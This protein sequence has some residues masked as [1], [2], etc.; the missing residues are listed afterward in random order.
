MNSTD[1]LQQKIRS[2]PDLDF[3]TIVN[4]SIELYK[5][6]WVQGLLLFVF[7]LLIMVPI[8]GFVYGPMYMEVIEEVKSGNSD[9]QAIND[10]VY[11]NSE[12]FSMGYYLIMMA[13]SAITSLLYAGFFR[14]VKKIDFNENFSVGEFFYFFS[15]PYFM[16]GFLLM[17]IT[18]LISGIATMLCFFPVFYVLVPIAYMMTFFAFNPDLSLGDIISL[19]FSLG[20]KKWGLTF[21]ICLLVILCFTIVYF[22]TCGIGMLFF[23]SFLFLP[24]YVIYK[25]V[26][27]FDEIDEIDKIGQIEEF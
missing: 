5:K 20:N 24:I 26:I 11:S 21:G 19:G 25:E 4:K 3:G 9:P 1:F 14:I 7:L 22:I 17:I 15:G 8:M 6:V 2:A 18:S 27:G 23:Y 12:M 10:I 16:K 13:V